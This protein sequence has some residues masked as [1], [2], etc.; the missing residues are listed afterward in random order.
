M[1]MSSYGMVLASLGSLYIYWDVNW[2]SCDVNSRLLAHCKPGGAI[3]W[4]CGAIPFNSGCI[5]A[6]PLG[7][8]RA[9]LGTVLRMVMGARARGPWAGGIVE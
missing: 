4:V 3:S 8:G 7:F 5:G 2:R 1:R 6:F 9:D